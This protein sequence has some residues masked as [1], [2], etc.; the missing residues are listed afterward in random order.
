[1]FVLAALSVAAPAGATDRIVPDSAARLHVVSRTDLAFTVE[2]T[3]PS[4][5]PTRFD[6]IGLYF[7]PDA[8]EPQRLG[9][10]S[11]ADVAIIPPHA[12]LSVTLQTLCLDEHREAPKET[13]HYTLASRRMPTALTN[14]LAVAAH[15]GDAQRAVWRVREQMPMPLIGDH[16]QLPPSPVKPVD[17]QE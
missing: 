5:A 16:A 14:A 3:N 1:L 13:A 2:I 15:T 10:V 9:V 17:D 11:A 6:A 7:V 4:D 8:S 12:S